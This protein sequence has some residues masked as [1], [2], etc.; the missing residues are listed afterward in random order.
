MQK[1]PFSDLSYHIFKKN[2]YFKND[3]NMYTS[4]KKLH[5]MLSV[6]TKID[7]NI[8]KHIKDVVNNGKSNLSLFTNQSC[9]FCFLFQK[10]GTAFVKVCLSLQS[11][12]TSRQKYSYKM[13]FLKQQQKSFWC[14]I[15]SGV[16]WNQHWLTVKHIKSKQSRESI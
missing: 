9:Q 13:K 16:W 12:V 3:Y 14:S 10:K 11:L 7:N 2:K 15:W 6:Y 5:L 4:I 1:L 8:F